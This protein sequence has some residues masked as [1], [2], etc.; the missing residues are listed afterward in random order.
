M[1]SKTEKM[2]S[3][4]LLIEFTITL[5]TTIFI[6]LFLLSLGF[7][8]YQNT[9]YGIVANETITEIS[10]T[11][12]FDGAVKAENISKDNLK[13]L[14][15][16]RMVRSWLGKTTSDRYKER[17]EKIVRERIETTSLSMN[18]KD[19]VNKVEL[20]VKSDK[21]GRCHLE[22]TIESNAKIFL[23]GVLEFF[24]FDSDVKITTVAI[25]ECYDLSAHM[26][27][28]RYINFLSNNA[29]DKVSKL[30]EKFSSTVKN[31]EDLFK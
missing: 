12:K 9:I 6:L 25:G 26:N 24:G 28:V 18:K 3:G 5:V 31:I 7:Y 8:F 1:K 13:D 21:F 30:I 29:N 14:K 27:T 4:E 17:I 2:Q 22:L 15:N 10:D 19:E 16:F 23:G 20:K 11:Y